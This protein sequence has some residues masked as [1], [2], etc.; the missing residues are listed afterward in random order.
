MRGGKGL[1]PTL[2]IATCRAFGGQSEDA[3]R[4]SSAVEMFHNAFLIHDDVEDESINRRG[5]RCM[6][7]EHGIPLAVNTGDSLNLLAVETV[8]SNIERLGFARTLRV[9]SLEARLLWTSRIRICWAHAVLRHHSQYS[10]RRRVHR[11]HA[12]RR[13][14]ERSQRSGYRWNVR[15][16]GA[17]LN[18]RKITIDLTRKPN[19]AAGNKTDRVTI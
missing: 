9:W 3:V 4:I 10:V 8:L 11:Q 1:R 15:W 17:G 7:V 6:H 14:L 19:D 12:L 16:A 13:P 18:T 5:K 2:C